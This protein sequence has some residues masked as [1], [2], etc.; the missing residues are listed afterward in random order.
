MQPTTGRQSGGSVGRGDCAK[1]G[2]KRDWRRTRRHTALRHV[3]LGE[4]VVTTT[5]IRQS[6]RAYSFPSDGAECLHTRF[7][8]FLCLLSLIDFFSDQS[9]KLP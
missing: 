1:A 3:S 8:V 6:R 2:R 5:T 7:S 4:S 9:V